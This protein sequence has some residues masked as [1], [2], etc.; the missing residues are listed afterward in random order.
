MNLRD[1]VYEALNNEI[2]NGAD[3]TDTPSR[4][5]AVLL[6]NW[7]YDLEGA[8]VDEIAVHVSEFLSDENE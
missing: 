4:D 7:L 5:V 2:S 1:R 8:D 3:F 6:L